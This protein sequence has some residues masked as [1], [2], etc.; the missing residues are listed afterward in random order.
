MIK[1]REIQHLPIGHPLRVQ[2]FREL[3]EEQK[4]EDGSSFYDYDEESKAYFDR[5]IAGDKK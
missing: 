1:Y 4:A 2:F 5:Y 3:E